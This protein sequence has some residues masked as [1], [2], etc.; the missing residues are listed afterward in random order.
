MIVG[1]W[2]HIDI[3]ILGQKAVQE[4]SWEVGFWFVSF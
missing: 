1:F 4:S 3:M 2:G